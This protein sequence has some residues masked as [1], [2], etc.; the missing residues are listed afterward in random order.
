MVSNSLDLTMSS[1]A[2]FNGQQHLDS[3]VTVVCI[4]AGSK[5]FGLLRLWLLCL[6]EVPGTGLVAAASEGHSRV[7]IGREGSEVVWLG[8]QSSAA[9]RNVCNLCC[10]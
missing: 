10:V 7:A 8:H 6:R 9:F 3:C 4:L 5:W 2:P 1:Q